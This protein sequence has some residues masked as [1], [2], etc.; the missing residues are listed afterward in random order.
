MATLALVCAPAALAAPED[1]NPVQRPPLIQV[2]GSGS[3]TPA[4]RGLHSIKYIIIHATDGGSLDGNVWWL[5]GSHSDASAHYVVS[6]LGTI[7]QLVNCSDI[8]WQ[9][10]NWKYNKE[11]IGIE[12]VGDTFDPNGF[13]KAQYVAS[14]HLVAWLV[15]RYS[16]PVNRRHIIG[17]YQVP[18]PNHPGEFGGADHHTD[19]GPYWRWG[20][21][22]NLI[23]HFAF[24]E[25]YAL[26][27]RITSL[28][29]DETLSGIV[30]W[31]IALT[32]GKV[33][34]VDFLVDGRLVWSDSRRPFRFAGGRGWNTTQVANGQHTLTV[35]VIGKDARAV[36]RIAVA[37]HNDAF[38]VTTAGLHPWQKVVGTLRVRANVHGAHTT[39]I[40]LYV[41]GHVVSRDRKAPF[42]LRWN[43][44]TVHDGEHRITVAAIAI[45]GRVSK[46][47]L[48][49][50]VD[51]HPV[52][53]RKPAKPRP[54]P[55]PLPP[56]AVTAENVADGETLSGTFIWRVHT[57]GPVAKLEF[58]VDGTV[59]ATSTAEPWSTA[60]DTT[61]VADGS[62]VLE[63]RAV[64]PSGATATLDR[65]VNVQQAPPPSTTSP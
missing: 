50:V 60:W 27:V 49:V 58:L 43:S 26:H 1:A 57:T 47:T 62:H 28:A 34:R 4:S 13:T 11:S 53:R 51:N 25:R 23:R 22:M 63:A 41:D 20:Y 48:P 5:S 3:Y 39:G 12:H 17:H 8:A 32:G 46:R 16:I 10:G 30:P 59:V 64:T 21:Y 52:R 24:P 56:P 61:S 54:R 14:A 18:D 40:G 29:D 19:P 35:R 31:R 9:A 7:V 55:K 33:E 38:G 37:V 15:R 2:H 6:R 65:T 45:D 42:S 36:K 44:R